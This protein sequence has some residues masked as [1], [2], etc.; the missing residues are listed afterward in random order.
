[1]WMPRHGQCGCRLYGVGGVSGA[2]QAYTQEVWITNGFGS[3]VEVTVRAGSRERYTISP[4]TLK[5]EP[6]KSQ[7]VVRRCSRS[8]PPTPPPPPKTFLATAGSPQHACDDR[9]VPAY[10]G[11][12]AAADSAAPTLPRYAGRDSQGA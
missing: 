10:R 9:L 11:L 5:L 6:G 3:R 8:L 7:K 1:M 2:W 4:T 12:H